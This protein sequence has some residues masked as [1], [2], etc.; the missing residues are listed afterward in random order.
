MARG[1][2]TREKTKFE[3]L[4]FLFKNEK[5]Q[6]FKDLEHI[7]SGA[8]NTV[9]K[10][11]E[12]LKDEGLIE[13]SLKGRHPYFLTEKGKEYAETESLKQKL[14]DQIDELSVERT[15]SLY[16]LMDKLV[17]KSAILTVDKVILEKMLHDF[18][19]G[20]ISKEKLAE[21]EKDYAK[22]K[23]E[24]WAKQRFFSDEEIDKMARATLSQ[25][26]IEKL[27]KA[28]SKWFEKWFGD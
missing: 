28:R 4:N 23:K 17:M 7:C 5:S 14:K 18:R 22:W 25:E 8:R 16:E 6:H 9:K 13:Q 20:K 10:Y 1:E 11:L 27:K 12:E 3:I 19:N 2:S 21:I 24:T 26:E 15:K